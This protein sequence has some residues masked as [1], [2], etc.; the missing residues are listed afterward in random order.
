MV[1]VGN[2][3]GDLPATGFTLWMCPEASQYQRRIPQ[4]KF[5]SSSLSGSTLSFDVGAHRVNEA[6]KVPDEFEFAID[7]GSTY[8]I[9]TTSLD[10]ISLAVIDINRA[11]SNP[12]ISTAVYSIDPP[13][14]RDD[15]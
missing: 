14:C 5:P 4:T 9:P 10:G 8:Q 7:D 1:Y 13:I 3:N 12:A 2:P 6:P 15:G 11:F